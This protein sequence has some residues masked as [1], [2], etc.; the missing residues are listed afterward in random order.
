LQQIR[1]CRHS[2]EKTNSAFSPD[3]ASPTRTSA[4]ESIG[5]FAE[6]P[7][8]LLTLQLKFELGE[9]LSELTTSRA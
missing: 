3:A 1:Q 9:N 5:F 7:L 6:H 4:L 8:S 2:L